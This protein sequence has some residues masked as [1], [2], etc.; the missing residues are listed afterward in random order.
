MNKTV[1]ILMLLLTLPYS[2]LVFASGSE[3]ESSKGS[4]V[5]DQRDEKREEKREEQRDAQRKKI[6]EEQRNMQPEKNKK[7]KKIK[8]HDD[9]QHGSATEKENIKNDEQCTD[10]GERSTKEK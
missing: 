2:S 3:T 7:K 10:K 1:F 9:H 6:R 4:S 5:Q 8:K